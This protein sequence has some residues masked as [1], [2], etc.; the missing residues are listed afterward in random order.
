MT[1]LITSAIPRQS[2]L[3]WINRLVQYPFCVRVSF[4]NEPRL[5][6]AA[7]TPRTRFPVRPQPWIVCRLNPISFS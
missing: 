3:L 4:F 2:S 1:A 6:N 5:A 7:R